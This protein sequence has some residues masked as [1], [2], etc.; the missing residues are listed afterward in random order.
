[1]IIVLMVQMVQF[2]DFCN[3]NNGKNVTKTQLCKLETK[4]SS[5]PCNVKLPISKLFFR[6]N[7]Q[8]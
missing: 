2:V 3:N 7:Y 5:E 1:M 6:L 4:S 8:K